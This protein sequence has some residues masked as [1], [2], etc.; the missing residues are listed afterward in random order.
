VEQRGPKSRFFV[1]ILKKKDPSFNLKTKGC[2]LETGHV[3]SKSNSRGPQ[4]TKGPGPARG[5]VKGGATKKKK[6]ISLSKKWM[7]KEK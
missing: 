3:K 2:W 5:G 1:V 6:N 7:C 4:G